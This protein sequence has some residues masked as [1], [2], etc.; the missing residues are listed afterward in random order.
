MNEMIIRN[1]ELKDV[2]DMK[3]LKKICGFNLKIF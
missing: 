2:K 3:F 1:M